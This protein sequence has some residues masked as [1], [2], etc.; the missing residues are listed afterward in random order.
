MIE[1][2]GLS[3]RGVETHTHSRFG[4]QRFDASSF[5]DAF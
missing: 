1:A 2:Q 4:G 5:L 3:A